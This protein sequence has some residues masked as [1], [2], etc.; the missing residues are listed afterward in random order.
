MGISPRLIRYGITIFF[1]FWAAIAQ[2]SV[3]VFAYQ[4]A[5]RMI[6]ILPAITIGSLTDVA[7]DPFFVSGFLIIFIWT[8]AAGRRRYGSLSAF[9]A[10][11]VKRVD[12]MF[13]YA[14]FDEPLVVGRI[15]HDDVTWKLEYWEDDRIKVIARECPFC[16][17][18]L[19]ETILPAHAVHAENTAFDP[20]EETKK[21]DADAWEDVFG[22]KKA[23]GR[24][25]THALVCPQ[26]NFSIP[27]RKDVLEGRDGAQAK[28][29]QHIDRMTASNPADDPFASYVRLAEAETGGTPSPEAIWDEYVRV[30]EAEDVCYIGV[31]SSVDDKIGADQSHSVSNPDNE[32]DAPT[33]SGGGAE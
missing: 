25:Q 3:V 17:L 22:A 24:K 1:L 26:C 15:K 8:G 18:E 29:R 6:P 21:S 20:G 7:T 33:P 32:P 27:G 14:L 19:A 4:F 2:F 5:E 16:N 30:S 10:A 11:I 28:F 9:A 31:V 13:G 23:D 12:D